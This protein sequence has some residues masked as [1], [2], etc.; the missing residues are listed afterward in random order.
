MGG[1]MGPRGPTGPIDLMRA[2]GPV[3]LM[4]ARGPIDLM[5]AGGPI[6]LMRA[7][8][9]NGQ[10]GPRNHSPYG[11]VNQVGPVGSRFMGMGRPPP[12]G[13]IRVHQGKMSQRGQRA[14]RSDPYQQLT[15]PSLMTWF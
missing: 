1:P 15:R 2:R 12:M 13:S 9:P 7:R 8:G 11:P 5:R 3:D 14:R 6:D 4:R 10:I